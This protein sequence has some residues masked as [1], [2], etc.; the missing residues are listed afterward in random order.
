M[1]ELLRARFQGLVDGRTVDLYTLRNR[2]GMA[3]RISNFGARIQQVLVPDRD[4]Q[5][6]DVVLGYDSLAAVLQDTSWLGAF[7]G[8]YANRIGG[9]RLTLNGLQYALSCN[10]GS[11]T[12]HGGTLGC[13]ARVFNVMHADE[14]R[15][16]L[17]YR[18][19]PEDDGFPGTVDLT[20]TYT[21]D[22]DNTLVV[23]WEAKALDQ[24]SVVSFSSHAY[25][26]LS[27]IAGSSILDHEVCIHAGGVLEIGDGQIPT[28]SVMAVEGTVFDLRQ[29]QVLAQTPKQGAY[30]HYWVTP[31]PTAQ[32]DLMLQARV[33]HGN[34]GRTLETWST[35]PGVQFYT[36][37]WLGS[38]EV[39]QSLHDKNGQLLVR[40]GALCLEPSAYP[41]APNH[42]HFPD[43]GVQPGALRTGKIVYRFGVTG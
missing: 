28:G 3:V 36:G 22:T 38:G 33:C 19:H 25:F 23:A 35:E 18:F 7:V 34:S 41:D 29:P 37:G 40:H 20:L 11:N 31:R 10:D 26:N 2:Q 27:G 42:P 17:A 24:P 5:M 8:R 14:E 16:V 32:T 4:G 13:S 39:G 21:V 30:D 12:L 15:L 43:A 1:N 9:A 6:A